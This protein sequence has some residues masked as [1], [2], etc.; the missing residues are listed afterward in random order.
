MLNTPKPPMVKNHTNVIGPKNFPMM[1]EPCL[2][3]KNKAVKIP[4]LIGKINFDNVGVATDKPSTADKSTNILHKTLNPQ[5][6][7]QYLQI[8]CGLP[9]NK[10]TLSPFNSYMTNSCCI[11]LNAKGDFDGQFWFI[12]F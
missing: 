4:M 12:S 1:A 3:T 7:T 11:F 8:I 6:F 9:F 10:F 5:K 2:C